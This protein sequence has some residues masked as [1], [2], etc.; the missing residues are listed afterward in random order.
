MA[1]QMKNGGAPRNRNYGNKGRT[2]R[3]ERQRFSRAELTQSSEQ[4]EALFEKRVLAEALKAPGKKVLR[5]LAT[6]IALKIGNGSRHE[7]DAIERKLLELQERK[8]L[9]GI[10]I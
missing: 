7:I 10:K 9:K 2:N 8:K 1:R 3:S 4:K 5:I 6:I